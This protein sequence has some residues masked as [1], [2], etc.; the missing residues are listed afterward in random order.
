MAQVL[1]FLH[2]L[3]G[4]MRGGI[5]FLLEQTVF[6]ENEQLAGFYGDVVSFLVSL[7]VIYLLLLL[8]NS[9]KKVI[10]VILFLGW[11]LFVVALV[12]RL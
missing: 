2:Y 12:V 6:R 3:Y 8:V 4:L 7:T 11:A 5:V 10:G 9:A 1:N